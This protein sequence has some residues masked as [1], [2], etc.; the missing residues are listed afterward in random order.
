M[1]SPAR[2]GRYQVAKICWLVVSDLHLYCKNIA[3]RK[4]YAGELMAVKE[5]C[6]ALAEG[7]IKR[8][9]DEA[10][11][12]LLGDVFH[13]GYQDVFSAVADSSFFFD[14]S[15]R[16]GRVYSVVGNHELHYWSG[17]PFFALVN[18]I[19]SEKLSHLQSDVW[20]PVGAVPA[21]N[22]ADRLECGEV[23]FHFNHYGTVINPPESGKVNIGL[24]HQEI[25]SRQ[26]LHA[27]EQVFG[28]GIFVKQCSA[29]EEVRRYQFCFFGHLHK[30]YGI[31]KT[32]D[33]GILCYL[34]S[35]GRTNS[36]EINDNF[37]ERRIP[38]VKV[39][40]GKFT[41]IDDNTFLLGNRDT[42]L[43]IKAVERA[44]V[45]YEVQKEKKLA[46]RDVVVG[47]NPIA[48]MTEYFLGDRFASLVLDGLL[49]GD[50]DTFGTAL[51]NKFRSLI[52]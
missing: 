5:Y 44:A 41:G 2:S 1:A 23:V 35:L 15:A 30:M 9:W 32:E 26:V 45:N 31:Y 29:L 27:A 49:E 43:D 34:A 13:R 33:G 20:T 3:N 52:R 11:L 38:V 48:N 12:L 39:E 36:G 7:Y 22:V 21:I 8:G 46:R 24:F 18:E 14:W 4:D 28:K 51:R 40:D 47:E 37:L 25:V 16:F 19:K 42:V 10:G 6:V 50:I 17:N